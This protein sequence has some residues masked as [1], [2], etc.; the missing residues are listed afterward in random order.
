MRAKYLLAIDQGTT[1]TR[2][3]IYDCYG[4]P[5]ARAYQEFKQY[6]PKPGWVEHDPLEIIRSVKRVV[7]QAIGMARIKGNVIHAIGITNQRETIVLWER[8]TGLPIGRAIVWQDRR[9][10]DLCASLKK[11]GK[12]SFV[13][14]RTGLFFDP[15]FSGTKLT[16]LFQHNPS[17]KKQAEAGE[18]CFG[19]IDSWIL[20]CLTQGVSHATDYTNA[21]R[22][23]L[24]NLRTKCW[25]NELLKIFRIPSKIL[26]EA[27]AS[28]SLF[29][30]VKN[31]Y[32][33]Q[34]G[35]P[36]HAIMGDQQSALYGESCYKPGTSKTTYG[37]GCFLLV[38]TGK[39]L[40]HSKSGLITTLACDKTGNPV[41]ALEAAIF[42]GGAV[43]QWLRDGLQ[44]IKSAHET[45][46]LALKAP[47]DDDLILIPAFTGLGAPHWRPDV[48][49]VLFGLTRGT[50]REAI[51]KAALKSIAHQVENIFDLVRKDA[52]LKIP[53][54]KVDGGAT[55]NK[56]LMQYQADLLGIPVLKARLQ[57]STAWGVAKLTGL[58]S[59][60]WS[61]SQGIEK[62][63]RYVK[64]SPKMNKNIRQNLIQKWRKAIQRLISTP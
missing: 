64:F 59:G 60:F 39:K 6:F 37:T 22:T 15:Y 11:A 54:L 27:K 21:S 38:N 51:A 31:F 47:A 40:V 24:F 8:K 2:A 63:E 3:I 17:L 1:G 56:Y 34:N 26:P 16:W 42:I 7:F 12:E 52:K 9:T 35:T 62:Q 45:E 32:P 23:L 53:A 49:G 41:Y 25:D 48:R 36:I 4:L 46:R 55:E 58:A 61:T 10:A 18:V 44:L 13:R 29:G 43:I 28:N 20:Y 19:T 14:N 57:E 30:Q 5:K 50:N 33:L